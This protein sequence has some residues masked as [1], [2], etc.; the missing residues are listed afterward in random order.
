[1][2]TVEAGETVTWLWD[3]GAN[4]HDVTADSFRSEAMSEGTFRHRFDEPG[5]YDYKCTLHT[6]MFGTIEVT[7]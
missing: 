6:N 3:D 5:T 1:M 4:D 2:L 7:A